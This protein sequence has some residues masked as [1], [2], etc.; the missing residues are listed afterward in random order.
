MGFQAG[1]G[2]DD[3]TIYLM[4]AGTGCVVAILWAMWAAISAYKGWVKGRVEDSAFGL[5]CLK[6]VFLVIIFYW[7]FI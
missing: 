2:F 6:V 7:V 3:N 1:A 4:L 5:A